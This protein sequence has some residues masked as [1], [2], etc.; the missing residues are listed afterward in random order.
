VVAPVPHGRRVRPYT[1]AETM[2]AGWCWSTPQADA[3]HR[4][5]VYASAFLSAEEAEAEMRRANPGMG[6]ARGVRFRA[7]RHEHFWLGNVVALGNAYGFVEPLESTA[8]HM[9]IR[10]IGLLAGLFPLRRGE[11]SLQPLLNRRVG[12]WWDYLRWFL[13]LHYRFNRRLDT[14]FWRACQ[15]E[16]DVSHHAE[17]LAAFRERG[18]LS[19]DPALRGA[20]DYPDPLWGPEGIDALLL[21]QGVPCHLPRPLLAAGAWHARIAQARATVAR[22]APHAAALDLLAV[23]PDLRER[24]ADAFRAAGPAFRAR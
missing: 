11:R 14:P 13:A 17:L 4:G 16:V 20:F 5:Y 2:T 21:G 24:F 3:D 22:A 10:Q 12:G 15:E 19:Y 9:L 6:P 8:L 7:G 23:R 18:P 1:T